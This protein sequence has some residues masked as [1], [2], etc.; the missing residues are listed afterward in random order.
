MLQFV[1]LVAKSSLTLCDSWTVA[2]QA[3]L[4]M[5]FPRHEYWSRLP[6]PS[7]GDFPESEIKPMYP[8]LAGG[9]FAIEPSGKPI[10]C[11]LYW[12]IS[13]NDVL[14]FKFHLVFIY[15]IPQVLCWNSTATVKLLWHLIFIKSMTLCSHWAGPTLLWLFL[16]PTCNLSSQLP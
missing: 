4:S 14:I 7:P 5:G 2:R 8:L 10:L 15:V 3:P 16:P 9:F 12:L 1:I 13:K 11:Q 6:F